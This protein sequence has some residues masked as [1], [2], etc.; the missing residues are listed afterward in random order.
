MTEISTTAHLRHP[1]ALVGTVIAIGL[2][3]SALALHAREGDP[4]FTLAQREAQ[5]IAASALQELVLTSS[6]PRPGHRGRARAARC[7]GSAGGGGLG[8]PWSCVVRYPQPPS[9]RFSVTVR[10]DR[11]IFG[12]AATRSGGRLTLSGCCVRD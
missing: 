5:P 10:A 9:V 3:G 11:S 12:I 2:A 1:G 6:D 4:Q 8:N 7:Q